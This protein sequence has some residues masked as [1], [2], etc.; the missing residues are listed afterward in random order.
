ME[1][2]KKEHE[3]KVSF[4]K[5]LENLEE[6]VSRLETGDLGLEDAIKE[7][8][9]GMGLAR[10]CHDKLEEA[11][12]KIEILQKGD[13]GAVEKKEVSVKKETGEIEDDDDLQGSL[14]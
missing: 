9:K 11:E 10:L 1:K 4:E 12:R 2:K 13:R 6:I 5:A 7:F 14:L 8:E 3:A